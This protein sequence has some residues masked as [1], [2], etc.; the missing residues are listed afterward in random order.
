MALAVSF[1]IPRIEKYT[2]VCADGTNTSRLPVCVLPKEYKRE[3]GAYVGLGTC[4]D[5]NDQCLYIT[6][7]P[8][9]VCI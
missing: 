6:L 1:K 7:R 2:E 4:G 5:D 3:S 8:L 9:V